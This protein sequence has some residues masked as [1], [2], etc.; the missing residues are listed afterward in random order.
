MNQQQILRGTVKSIVYKNESDGFVI[1]CL[2]VTEKQVETVRGYLMHLVKGEEIIVRGSWQLHKKFGKQFVAESVQKLLPQT[3]EGLVAYLGSGLIKG[4]G[5]T[6]AQKL[7]DRFGDNVISI[8]ETD[9]EQ[10]LTIPGIGASR[11][12]LIQQSIVEQKEMRDVMIFLQEKGVSTTYAAKIFKHYRENTIAILQ[13]NPYRLAEEVWGIGFKIADAIAQKIGIQP[14]DPLRICAGI[15]SVLSMVQGQGSVYF[16][17]VSLK[18]Q[19]VTL[20]A[21]PEEEIEVHLVHA[22][23][24]LKNQG[25]IKLILK[26]GTEFFTT[27]FFYFAEKELGTLLCD[28][29]AAFEATQKRKPNVDLIA[30]TMPYTLAEKQIEGLK[31]TLEK[32][33]SIITGGPG[34]GKT[35]VIKTLLSMLDR[36]G[37]SY[38]LTAPTGRAAKRMKESSGYEAVTIHR[39]LEFDPMTKKFQKNQSSLLKADFIIVDEASMIDVMLAHSL[40]KAIR[41][42]SQLLC[43]GDIDQL[44]SVGAGNVLADMIESGVIPY[45]KLTT[46]FRQSEQS[47]IVMNAHRINCGKFP[48]VAVKKERP[49]FLYIEETESTRL[50]DH[51]RTIFTQTL[52]HY[53]ISQDQTIV[54]SPM[55][56]GVAGTGTINLFLQSILN[57]ENTHK[58]VSSFGTIF[59]KNDRVMQLRNNYDKAVFN[60][61]IGVVESIDLDAG[62]LLVRFL[63]R[64]IKYEQH[65]TQE[66]MLAY[67][68]SIHKS[69]GS[70]YDAVIV[71]IFMQHFMMLQKNL[72]YTALTR[73]KKLCIFIGEKRAIAMALKKEQTAQRVTFLKEYLRGVNGVKS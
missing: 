62:E 21:I 38:V 48:L 70:E 63:D 8:I 54:L 67:A 72:L 31:M 5:P 7:V 44:P 22:L 30:N 57:S 52:L 17:Q 26:E 50:S 32:G 56:R 53:D 41:P 33:V 46:V 15:L 36:Y 68:I 25:K 73:A 16:D 29:L 37:I 59:K 2:F 34:T 42:G 58:L 9:P 61:D 10:L 3:K 11:L 47:M 66:L 18:Q 55:H 69:Q 43:I 14:S 64:I 24:L 45:T 4:V 12:A 65:E 40:V 20:L 13:E 19:L 51:L 6:Y 28:L 71:P 49:E 35:T 60:G 1:C 23:T 27:T 39:L